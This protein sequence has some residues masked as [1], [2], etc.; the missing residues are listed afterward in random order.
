MSTSRGT[1]V[2]GS[3]TSTEMPSRA[4]LLRHREGLAHVVRERHDGHVGARALHLGH[5]ERHEVVAVGH[6]ARDGG[7]AAALER[8]HGIVVADR[9]LQQ[10]LGVGRRR[11]A[12]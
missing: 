2:R 9:A 12:G 10:P 3:T 4:E 5:A 1:S 8:D 6:G 11:R 7:Q